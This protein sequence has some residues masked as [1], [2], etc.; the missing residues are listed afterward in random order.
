MRPAVLRT[1]GRDCPNLTF[2]I[3]FAPCR[4]CD[5]IAPGA[6]ENEKA[7]DVAIRPPEF[8]GRAPDKRQLARVKHAVA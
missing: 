5:F 2:Q 1:L 4:V 3:D 7:N 6:G 8:A